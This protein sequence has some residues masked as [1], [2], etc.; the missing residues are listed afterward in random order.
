MNF[1]HK[2]LL[3][4]FLLVS[5]GITGCSGQEKHAPD[6]SSAVQAQIAVDTAFHNGDIIFQTSQSG[7]SYAIQLATH[8]IYSHCGILFN[9]NGEWYVYEAVQP[10]MKTPLSKW[11]ARGDSGIYVVKRLKNADSLLTKTA[12]SKMR[13]SVH[14]KMGKNYDAW[15]GWSNENIYCSELVWK[16]YNDATGL[17]VGKLKKLGE[18]DLSHPIVK[19]IMYERYGNKPPLD[20]PMIS[21]GNIYESDLLMLV[22]T[23]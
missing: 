17:E 9:D 4:P 16:A 20:E 1:I 7:Q 11:I 8:S 15:F 3:L 14:D 18:Y 19:K 2:N 22:R 23:N 5:L 21:P 12:L 13:K 10:V 6:K